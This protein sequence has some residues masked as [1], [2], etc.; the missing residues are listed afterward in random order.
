MSF[1]SVLR[2]IVD[3]CGGGLGAALM[4]A[5]GIPIEQVAASTAPPEPAADVATLGVEFGR[6]LGELRKAADSVGGGGLEELA[7]RLANFWV[8]IEPVDEENYLVVAVGAGGN[9]GKARFLMRRHRISLRE[10]L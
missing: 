4:G 7:L 2:S 10:L 1:A 9:P 3:E 5:D 6:V 8:L